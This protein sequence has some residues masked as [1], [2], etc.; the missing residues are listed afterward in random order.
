MI[1]FEIAGEPVPKGRPRFR[2]NFARDMVARV[3]EEVRRGRAGSLLSFLRDNI[4]VMT[5]TP[6]ET[7]AAEQAFAWQ[8]KKY[9]PR[10]P[11][12]GPL[13]V[14]TVFVVTPPKKIPPDRSR[15]WPHVKPDDDNY[16][17]LVLDALNGIFWHD[18]GQICGGESFKIYGV[19]RTFVRITQL[20]PED[21]QRVRHEILGEPASPQP[22]LFGGGS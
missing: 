9:S 3:V 22:S 6:P 1:E 7:E 5:Y 15:D 8:S 4:T 12:D 10:K 16:R 17:K 11:L 19:P 14:L 2:L 18:D 20:G 21:V 13:S